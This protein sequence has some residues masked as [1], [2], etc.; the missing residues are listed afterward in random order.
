MILL[1]R[2]LV[3]A[4]LARAALVTSSPGGGNV[5]VAM[6]YA[7]VVASAV[8]GAPAYDPFVFVEKCQTVTTCM[9]HVYACV[10]APRYCASGSI[11][12]VWHCPNGAYSCWSHDNHGQLPVQGSHTIVYGAT[13][14]TVY[15][16]PTAFNDAQHIAACFALL[17][18]A[19]YCCSNV[20]NALHVNWTFAIATLIAFSAPLRL[21]PTWATPVLVAA[22]T[23]HAVLRFRWAHL[24]PGT[25]TRMLAY[26]AIL[27]SLPEQ[28]IGIQPTLFTQFIVGLAVIVDCGNLSGPAFVPILAAIWSA[29][30]STH[31]QV[32]SAHIGGEA[33]LYTAAIA[34]S[35]FVAGKL[36]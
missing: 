18:I 1:N 12:S 31:V 5:T 8:D 16:S 28:S 2:V 23:A 13:G 24:A 25:T 22:A 32:L 7:A 26:V 36:A 10:D 4:R 33:W 9:G 35:A 34:W 27:I 3:Q 15:N 11:K 17:A 6:P 20:A 21:A 29:A 30:T 14:A 19:A